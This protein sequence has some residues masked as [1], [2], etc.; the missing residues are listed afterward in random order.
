VLAGLLLIGLIANWQIV[1]WVFRI[2]E[3]LG[4]LVGVTWLTLV[5]AA[6]VGLARIRRSGV[7]SLLVL[8]PFSTVMLS[9]PLLPGMRLVGLDGPIALAA[10]N[11]VALLGGV[12]VFWAPDG[13]ERRDQVT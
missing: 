7:Y 6:V 8:A 5:I 12:A 2:R 13:P 10:W 9:V 1:F 11:L 4:L 3:L